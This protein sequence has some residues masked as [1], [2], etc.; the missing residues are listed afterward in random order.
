MRQGLDSTQLLLREE[1]GLAYY[2]GF[3]FNNIGRRFI[4]A[5]FTVFFTAQQLRER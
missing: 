1:E 5:V 3:T 2:R 4:L